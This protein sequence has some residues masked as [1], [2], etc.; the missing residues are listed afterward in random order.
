MKKNFI[1]HGWKDINHS[2]SIVNQNQLLNLSNNVHINLFHYEDK[3]YNPDW[4]NSKNSSGLGDENNQILN[5][6]KTPILEDY[7]NSNVYSIS[8]PFL[9]YKTQINEKVINF[10]VTEFGITGKELENGIESIA[11]FNDSE[12]FIVT[13]SLWSK[14]KI[15]NAGFDQ[16][17]IKVIPHGIDTNIY[18]PFNLNTRNDARVNIG[19][20]DNNFC[21]LN[22]SSMTWNKGIDIL[23]EAYAKVF[24]L[25]PSC[26]LILK[27][28]SNL[29]GIKAQDYILKFLNENNLYNTNQLI[30]SIIIIN[31]NLTA[32]EL[33][34]LYNISD[35]YVAP[36]RAE[37]F[38]IPV[39]ESMA[40]GTPVIVTS[41]GSTDDFVN[42]HTEDWY[43]I[44]SSEVS[45]F[46]LPEQ[47]N[48]RA[49]IKDYH[50]KPNIHSLI[51]NMIASIN[52]NQKNLK[53]ATYI[54]EHFNWNNI[55]NLI[56]NNYCL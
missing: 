15:I 34:T 56:V 36:Y 33:N 44:E 28:Q 6:I 18:H 53:M 49:H 1:V 25:Y 5:R 42:K 16:D 27:D 45:N 9:N 2:F 38:N 29:Y 4:N 31:Q 8:Y 12:N 47:F 3:K 13:P 51:H 24:S 17:K 46:N 22:V 40:C 11:K 26:K 35:C 54:K 23:L 20:N 50:L 7:Y 19:I 14:I 10:I 55:S 39:L 48:N 32:Y 30:E 21:F 43:L 37:G 52:K 41:G